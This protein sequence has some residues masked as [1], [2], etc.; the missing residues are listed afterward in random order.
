MVITLH[1]L[2]ILK[3]LAFSITPQ[4]Q[5]LTNPPHGIFGLEILL[6]LFLDIDRNYVSVI[7]TIISNIIA[8]VSRI[9]ICFG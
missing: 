8:L 2:I 7:I 4:F 1:N 3:S 5:N 6:K 9:V